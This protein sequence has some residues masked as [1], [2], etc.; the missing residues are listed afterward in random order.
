MRAR[1]AAD[2]WPEAAGAR[3]GTNL[4]STLWRANRLGPLLACTAQSLRLSDGVVVDVAEL[5]AAAE[6]MR[7]GGIAQAPFLATFN[8][9]LLPGWQE[10]WVTLERERL[11]QLELRVLDFLVDGPSRAGPARRGPRRRSA[12]DPPGAAARVCPTAHLI[13]LYVA[14]GNRTAALTHYQGFANLL[15]R[16]LD[17]PGAGHHGAGRAVP[18]LRPGRVPAP[19]RLR[20]EAGPARAGSA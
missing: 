7:A 2:L 14:S 5:A 11:R 17:W 13:R 20:G 1:V 10:D 12:G 4:R 18:R 9:E 3:A 15:H 19:G 8:L 16:E 6:Q